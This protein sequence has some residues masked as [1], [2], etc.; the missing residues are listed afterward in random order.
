MHDL[1]V[2]GGTVVDGTG[3]APFTADVAVRDGLIV[4]VGKLT[5]GAR[6]TIDADGAIVTP[7]WVDGHTHYDGQV[8]WDDRLDGS[9][10]N[11]VTTVVMGN[12]GVGFA[13]VPARRRGRADRPDGRCRGHPRHR[14]V[15][16][17]AVGELGVVPRV[18]RASSTAG[19]GPST[20]ALSWPTARCATT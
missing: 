17:D 16:G 7:G 11:G 9:A 6:Q 18:P 4:D 19:A 20:S 3:A 13:P 5:G 12:C 8:T 15:R 1:V 10:S 14:A 2:K